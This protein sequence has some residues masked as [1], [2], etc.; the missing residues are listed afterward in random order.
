MKRLSIA[1]ALAAVA[2]TATG[3]GGHSQSWQDGYDV[4]M[5]Y[6]NTGFEPTMGL[7]ECTDGQFAGEIDSLASTAGDNHDEE[8]A[9]C[10]QAMRDKGWTS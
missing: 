8:V 6:F 9:G 1:L 2:A 5:S 3:C 4:A 7:A 10:Q